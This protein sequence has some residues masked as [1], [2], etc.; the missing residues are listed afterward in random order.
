MLARAH[1]HEPT[2]VTAALHMHAEHARTAIVLRVA[3]DSFSARPRGEL[4]GWKKR[5]QLHMRIVR[6]SAADVMRLQTV[7]TEP[8]QTDCHFCIKAHRDALA[9]LLPDNA[10]RPVACLA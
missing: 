10:S 9:H 6:A 3:T 2:P 5:W 4:A 8:D 7:D 1:A